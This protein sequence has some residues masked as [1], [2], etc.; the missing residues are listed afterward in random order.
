VNL[1][2]L[3]V[4]TALSGIPLMS[5]LTGFHFFRVSVW[6]CGVALWGILTIRR[7][8]GVRYALIL[9]WKQLN[10]NPTQ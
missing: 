2:S 9:S 7:V 6:G 4:H 10:F 8:S 1:L 5:L 3:T